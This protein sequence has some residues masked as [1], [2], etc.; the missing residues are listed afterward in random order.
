MRIIIVIKSAQIISSNNMFTQV[1][2]HGEMIYP[3]GF[4]KIIDLTS[5]ITQLT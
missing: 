3:A 2:V 5:G 1:K 4:N